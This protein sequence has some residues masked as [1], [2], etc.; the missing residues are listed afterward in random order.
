M[1]S[2]RCIVFFTVT[3]CLI[4]SRIIQCFCLICLAHLVAVQCVSCHRNTPATRRTRRDK[5]S[6]DTSQM[7]KA[8]SII[9]DALNSIDYLSHSLFA[10]SPSRDVAQLFCDKNSSLGFIDLVS[11]KTDPV[12]SLGHSRATLNRSADLATNRRDENV[13]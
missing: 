7:M 12:S 5:Q 11:T 6:M 10:S 3:L 8:S 13:V 2:S 4:T 9:L 1:M